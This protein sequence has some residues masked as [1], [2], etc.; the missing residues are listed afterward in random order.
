MERHQVALWVVVAT[1][2]AFIIWNYLPAQATAAEIPADDIGGDVQ[3]EFNVPT[4]RNTS[5]GPAYLVANSPFMFS[6]PV[7][8]I[9]PTITAGQIGE[10]AGQFNN[11]AECSFC[12]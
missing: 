2:A 6:P 4:P 7:Q 5:L 10:V 1:L 3:M 8:N 12:Q 11:G 9:L